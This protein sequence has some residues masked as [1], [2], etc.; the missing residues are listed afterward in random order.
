MKMISAGSA[1]IV[2]TAYGD[3][4]L[5]FLEALNRGKF[6]DAWQFDASIR[7]AA[8]QLLQSRGQRTIVLVS[9]GGI[10]TDPYQRYSLMQ[11]A[12]FLK[13]NAVRFNALFLQAENAS[14]D[15]DY[16]CSATGGNSAYYY[17]PQGLES[18]F[19]SIE[20]G[21]D[22]RYVVSFTSS[23]D[24]DFGKRFIKLETEVTLQRKSGFDECGYFSPLQF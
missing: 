8:N 18:F 17:R 15:I 10:G 4:R 9:Q 23:V 1:P 16:L 20:K 3:K 11:L 2:E 19:Q 13:N 24:P 22:P 7:L 14:P 21:V 5:T 12:Q 6:T